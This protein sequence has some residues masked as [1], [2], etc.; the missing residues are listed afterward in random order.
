MAA[1]LGERAWID[2][3]ISKTLLIKLISRIRFIVAWW[4]VTA[5]MAFAASA[6][7]AFANYILSFVPIYGLYFPG[8]ASTDN[9]KWRVALWAVSEL[10][11]V[12]TTAL[13]Y[14][15]RAYNSVFFYYRH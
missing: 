2:L 7:L 12:M 6:A 14:L 13:A 11:L 3:I 15:P 4:A 1:S 5:W 8:G 9:I 10:F